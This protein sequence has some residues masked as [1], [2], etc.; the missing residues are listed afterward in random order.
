MEASATLTRWFFG[1]SAIW[2]PATPPA[3]QFSVAAPWT[4]LDLV[5][6]NY[7]AQGEGGVPVVFGSPIHTAVEGGAVPVGVLPDLIG[8]EL[9][10]EGVA[11][12]YTGGYYAGGGNVK[13]YLADETGGVQVWVPGGEGEVDIQIGDRVQAK[14]KLAGVP[15]GAGIG[16]ERPGRYAMS[17]VRR[18]PSPAWILTA[19]SIAQ[20][21]N[22]PTLAGKLVQVTGIVARN[23]EF[24]YSYELDLVDESGQLITLYVD[25]LT[26]IEVEAIENGQQYHAT[27]ILEMFDTRQQLYPRV[28]A[29]LERVYPAVLT[30]ELGAPNTVVPGG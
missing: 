22:D 2:R 11:S 27:G 16:G 13:F 3:T 1:R 8:Q 30:L 26:N 21:A 9:V 5:V 19:A 6:A 15:R 20:A 4:Y 14:G 17:R 24:S 23:E 29:D 10:V 12:M 7:S 18:S 28:Q 25:K